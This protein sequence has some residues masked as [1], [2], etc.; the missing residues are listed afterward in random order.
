MANLHT[1]LCF[2][3]GIYFTTESVNLHRKLP[4]ER[5]WGYDGFDRETGQRA[6]SENIHAVLS[7]SLLH[8]MFQEGKTNFD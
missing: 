1:L 5:G 4:A 8:A 6:D 3:I 7:L 2:K